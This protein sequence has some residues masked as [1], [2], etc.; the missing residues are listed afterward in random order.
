M[1][2]E[3]KK[4][5]ASSFES[6][7]NEELGKPGTEK[8]DDFQEELDRKLLGKFFQALRKAANLSQKEVAKLMNTNHTYISKIETGQKQIRIDTVRKYCRALNAGL[9]LVVKLPSGEQS[10]LTLLKP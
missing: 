8:R 9:Q 2:T 1:A 6:L 7:L 3:E 10:R 5:T 4:Y